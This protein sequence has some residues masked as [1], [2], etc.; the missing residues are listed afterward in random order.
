MCTFVLDNQTQTELLGVW[1][2]ATAFLF[3]TSAVFIK[4]YFKSKV[5]CRA[6]IQFISYVY[7]LF[8]VSFVA[9]SI[10]NQTLAPQWILL[11]PIGILGLIGVKKYK[12]S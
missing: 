2:M 5:E 10:I 4:N 6:I 1:H 11:L 12:L 3:F 7:F 9:V 8:S